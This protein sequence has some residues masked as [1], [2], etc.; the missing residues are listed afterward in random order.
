MY[1]EAIAAAAGARGWAVLW[2]DRERVF[3]DA[4]TALGCEDIDA[5]LH[6]LGKAVGPPWQARHKLAAAAAMASTRPEHAMDETDFEGTLVLEALAATGKVD[7]FFDAI[8]SDDVG[9][10]TLLLK[11]AG[12]DATTIAT[13]IRKIEDADGEH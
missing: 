8:D 13:V 10:A 7:E 12:L 1:R 2:Y 9:R 5:F 11:A 3:S 6:T 4:A